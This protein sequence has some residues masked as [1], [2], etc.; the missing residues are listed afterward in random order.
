MHASASFLQAVYLLLTCTVALQ[1]AQRELQQYTLIATVDVKL[2]VANFGYDNGPSHLARHLG[3]TKV[4]EFDGAGGMAGSPTW[5]ADALQLLALRLGAAPEAV[6]PG[7]NCRGVFCG[8]SR[9]AMPTG[10]RRG[11]GAS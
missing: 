5:A 11:K 9:P 8:A 4:W 3:D 10:T 6:Q 1:E 7:I 2:P